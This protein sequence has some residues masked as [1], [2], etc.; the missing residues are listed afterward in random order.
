MVSN[1]LY[2]VFLRNATAGVEAADGVVVN[3]APLLGKFMGQPLKNLDGWVARN[4][5]TMQ[6]V[7]K[8]EL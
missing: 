4:G 8:E 7:S 1:A 2:Q 3:A 5:G 6:L